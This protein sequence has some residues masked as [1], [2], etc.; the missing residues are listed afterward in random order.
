MLGTIVEVGVQANALGIPVFFTART[1]FLRT[2]S[3]ASPARHPYGDAPQRP[4][5]NAADRACTARAPAREKHTCEPRSTAR[6]TTD[7]REN[8]PTGTARNTARSPIQNQTAAVHACFRNLGVGTLRRGTTAKM[9]APPTAALSRA[10]LS[11]T[12]TCTAELSAAHSGN[13]SRVGRSH[14]G[15]SAPSERRR[16]LDGAESWPAGVGVPQC[17]SALSV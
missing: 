7:D 13:T 12:F 4:W 17:V 3:R 15:I 5:A 14:T 11:H 2:P 8:L 10:F 6:S 1:S 16:W 9:K